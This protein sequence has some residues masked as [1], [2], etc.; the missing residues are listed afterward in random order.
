VKK[1]TTYRQTFRRH[2]LL[3]SLPVLIGVLI[4]G[5]LTF[6][7]GKSYES[8]ASLWVDNPATTDSS[9]GNLNPAMTPP[10]TEEQDVLTELLATP[11]FDLAVGHQSL[12]GPYL[13]SHKS[14]GISSIVGGG[15]SLDEQIMAALGAT[16]V[17]STIPGPQVLQ[18]S[19]IG[20]TPAVAQST[21]K[22]IVAQL[23]HDSATF[24]QQHSAGA[25]SYFQAQ[26]NSASQ[27]LVSA[28]NQADAYRAQH[29]T[30]TSQSD[31]NLAALVS[32]ETSAGNSLAQAQGL[33]SQ[34]KAALKGGAGATAATIVQ[35]IDAPSFPV[36][37]TAGKK[38][39][40]EGILAGLIGGLVVAFLG[41][42]ALT[43]RESDPW[44][45]E[46]AEAA[47]AGSTPAPSAIPASAHVPSPQPEFVG[48]AAGHTTAPD[49]AGLSLLS[50][51]SALVG[52]AGNGGAH[53][54]P[55]PANGAASPNGGAF[56]AKT[57]ARTLQGNG[58]QA[59]SAERKFSH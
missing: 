54:H 3:L 46:L 11:G 55:R 44:E 53:T 19:Y 28:R 17:T 43:R 45:D 52:Q 1:S 6:T 4:A 50:V 31:P 56:I 2:R 16:N 24:A 59:F 14:A 48:A 29:P 38:K 5:G 20:P 40:V 13:A 22:A 39:Q 18:I 21:L 25:L 27:A 36:G 47:R 7:S 32:A 10:S 12:L 23:Q 37:P 30:A 26:V 49:G 51:D 8:S 42:I 35:T 9:L 15:G 34:S 33:L 41:T 58:V 57:P